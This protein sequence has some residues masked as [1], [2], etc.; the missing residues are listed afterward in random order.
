MVCCGAV[1]V[2]G[3]RDSLVDKKTLNSPKVAPALKRQW[4]QSASAPRYSTLADGEKP[5]EIRP[6]P[7][8][9]FESIPGTWWFCRD[10]ASYNRFCKTPLAQGYE[11]L[12]RHPGFPLSKSQPAT[13]PDLFPAER[14][15]FYF[16]HRGWLK[17]IGLSQPHIF[18]GK[19]ELSF[20]ISLSADR[21]LSAIESEFDALGLFPRQ[22][23]SES[24]WKTSVDPDLIVAKY[25]PRGATE[26]VVLRFNRLTR[27]LRKLKEAG[28][29]IRCGSKSCRHL[30]HF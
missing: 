21:V 15:A 27:H 29:P 23:Y 28:R 24:Y 10:Q 17:R 6:I 7:Q 20:D 9:A 5:G 14:E 11:V 1:A 19:R 26:A 2:G 18:V 4:R 25:G 8:P 30:K 3:K 13:W 22:S 16:S 12:R